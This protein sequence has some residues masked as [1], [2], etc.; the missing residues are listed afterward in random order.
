MFFYL[1]VAKIRYFVG[2]CYG[3]YAF[4]MND[5]GVKFFVI[6]PYSGSV[7]MLFLWIISN[8]GE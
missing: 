7:L 5:Y 2:I 1:D 8:D 4:L 6:P 3:F